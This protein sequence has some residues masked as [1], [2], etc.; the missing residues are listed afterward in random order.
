MQR[1]KK[2]VRLLAE[3]QN[4]SVEYGHDDSILVHTH[5]GSATFT[6]KSYEVM[7]CSIDLGNASRVFPLPKIYV[8]DIVD[9]LGT[10]HLASTLLDYPKPPL[11][12]LHDYINDEHGLPLLQGLQQELADNPSIVRKEL[13]GNRILAEY[14]RGVLAL[15][16][17]LVMAATNVIEFGASSPEL[18]KAT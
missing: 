6:P 10:P 7:T 14:F 1:F 13:G 11:L 15:R 4:S 16:D 9:R 8:F 5:S 17:D 3:Q 18:R 12:A 2:R